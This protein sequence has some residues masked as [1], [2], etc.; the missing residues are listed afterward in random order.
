[1]RLIFLQSEKVIKLLK[2]YDIDSK[3]IE[4]KSEYNIKELNKLHK[5]I[6]QNKD[7]FEKIYQHTIKMNI[8]EI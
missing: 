6:L 2:K 7:S 5:T 1:M 4:I 3:K 8:V